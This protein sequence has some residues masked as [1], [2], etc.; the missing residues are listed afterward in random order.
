MSTPEQPANPPPPS[1]TGQHAEAGEE[2]W[3]RVRI[4]GSD[5]GSRRRPPPDHPPDDEADTPVDDARTHTT[6]G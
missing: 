4:P 5:Q 1:R 2:Q 3:H 6:G